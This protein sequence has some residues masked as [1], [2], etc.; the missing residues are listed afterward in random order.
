MKGGVR[1]DII[2]ASVISH[3]LWPKFHKGTLHHRWRI[4]DDLE[5]QAFCDSLSPPDRDGF[6]ESPNFLPGFRTC[7]TAT[8]AVDMLVDGFKGFP[9]SLHSDADFEALAKS[10]LY[11]SVAAAYHHSAAIELDADIAMRVRL[12]IK[13]EEILCHSTDT[14]TKG[15]LITPEFMEEMAKK[16]HQLPPSTLRLFRGSKVRLLRNF[17]PSRGL[18]NGTILIVRKV[19]RHHIEAQILSDTEFNGN[20]EI[21]FRFKF[22]VET[23][24]ISFSRVQFPIASAFAGTVHRFQ[25]QSVPHQSQLLLDQRRNPFCHGQAYVA[26][27]RG[28]NSRQIIIITSPGVNNMKCLNYKELLFGQHNPP[29]NNNV[30]LQIEEQEEDSFQDFSIPP[31]ETVHV[32]SPPFEGMHPLSAANLDDVDPAYDEV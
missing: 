26:M 17:H 12:R 9:R 32:A 3:P 8:M 22:D 16:D 14:A 6:F 1:S 4:K 25:G 5:F 15:L 2:A 13:E 18:C 10:P 21:L 20:I 7:T 30:N 29:P 19:G 23:K 28:R 27:S 24:A 31:E 11:S